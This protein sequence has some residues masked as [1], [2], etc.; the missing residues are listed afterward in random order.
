MNP[1]RMSD[2]TQDGSQEVSVIVSLTLNQWFI[3]N[4]ILV[5]GEHSM[6]EAFDLSLKEMAPIE[7][8][9]NT[10]ASQYPRFVQSYIDAQYRKLD[11]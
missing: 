1:A 9:V 3:F 8:V 11:H 6:E 4:R 7:T 2:K 10:V 5:R